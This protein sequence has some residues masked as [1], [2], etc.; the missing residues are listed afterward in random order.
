MNEP[1]AHAPHPSARDVFLA[2]AQISI[3]GF[4]GVLFWAR[5]VLVEQRR[6]LTEKEFVEL[7]ALGQILPGP[8]IFNVSVMLGDRYAGLGGVFAAMAGF[9]GVPFL[10]VTGFAVL[11][12]RYGNLAVVQQAL[13]GMSAA[14]VGLLI[15]N[16]IRM[17]MTLP[18]HWRAWA[19]VALAFACVGVLRLPLIG[20]LAV[21][22]P[23]GVAAAWKRRR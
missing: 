15:A 11:Y 5:R 1:G 7:L 3:S 13:A 12:Q 10:I 4:G 8:N 19:F 17:T 23:L 20:V 22:A 18:R 9:M 14:A 21:L 16:G 6:W 2:F